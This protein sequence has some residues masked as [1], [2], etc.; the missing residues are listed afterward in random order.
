MPKL[1]QILAIEKQ[2][3]AN[4]YG[5]LTRLHQLTQKTP[6]L[7]GL[8]RSYQPLDD[9]GEKFPP[10]NHKLQLRL[11][12]AINALT[13]A[14]TPLMDI[15]L[16][17]DVANTEAKADIV[18]DGKVLLAQVPATYLL[19]LEKQLVD[20]GTFITKLPGLPP[21]EDWTYDDQQDC[22]RSNPVVTAKAKKIPKPFVKAEATKE[23]PAQVEV[24]HEDVLQGYWT[25]IK[26]C[27]GLPEHTLRLMRERCEKLLAAVRFAREQANLVE[28]RPAKAGEALLDYLFAP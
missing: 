23:H 1:N 20:L 27:G 25:T 28:V 19:W 22:Y 16:Q 13:K 8:S 21:D 26:Y 5:E 3:K 24:V 17:R 15:T 18:V 14:L 7:S 4:A 10:E 6:L 12:T 2:T 9:E 11:S